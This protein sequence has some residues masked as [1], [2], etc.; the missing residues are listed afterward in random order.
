MDAVSFFQVAEKGIFVKFLKNKFLIDDILN[1][2]HPSD[3][4]YTKDYSLLILRLPFIKE[5]EV[6]IF[7]YVFLIKENE[8]FIFDRKIKD[9]EKLGDFE[10]LYEYL[11][12]RVDK[13]LVKLNSFHLEIAKIEDNMYDD[14]FES[15]FSKKW[16]KLK[17]ELTLIERHLSHAMIAYERFLKYF[18][19]NDD[20]AFKDLEEHLQRAFSFSKAAIEKLDYLYEFFKAKQDEKMNKIM[21][22]LTII[23]GIF[24]P[25]TLI[26]GFFGMNTGGLP[27][28]NDSFGTIKATVI[29]IILEIPFIWM[30][31]YYMKKK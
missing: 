12:I 9:F 4:D 11:D 15:D 2:E 26:T 6:K 23:S 22:V 21:F 3:F 13:I 8:V 20:F 17:K 14:V 1:T 7:S 25:L 24:L 30:L 28:T 31:W 10:K 5:D 19:L 16:L 29:G 18:K 27:F